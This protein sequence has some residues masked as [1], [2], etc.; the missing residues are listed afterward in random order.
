MHRQPDA[1]RQLQPCSQEGPPVETGPGTRERRGRNG[2]RRARHS[3]ARPILGRPLLLPR[4]G[5]GKIEAQTTNLHRFNAELYR[6]TD[7]TLYRQ[8]ALGY[9]GGADDNLPGDEY[10]GLSEHFGELM[11]RGAVVMPTRG[12]PNESVSA[13]LP[14]RDLLNRRREWIRQRSADN[15]RA[16]QEILASGARND[17][18][19]NETEPGLP[20]EFFADSSDFEAAA[21][22]LANPGV[23]ALVT[24]D[25]GSDCRDGKTVAEHKPC[26]QVVQWF[27]DT[28]IGLTFYEGSDKFDVVLRSLETGEALHGVV[29]LVTAGNRVLG[30]LATDANG[31]A[32]F[33]KSLTRGTQSNALAAIMAQ[34]DSDKGLGDFAFMTFNSERLDLSK[35]NVDG[36]TLPAG[37]DAFLT[38]DR[39]LYEPGQTIELVALL[40]D[41]KGE[42]IEAPPRA[43]VRLEARDRV[44][45]QAPIEPSEWKLGGARKSIVLPKEARS[46]PVRVVLSLGEGENAAV[47]ETLIHIGPIKPDQSTCSFPTPA[48]PGARAPITASSKSK[49]R[50]WRATCL[51]RKR[52]SSARRGICA[53]KPWRGFRPARPR[54]RPATGGSL[55]ANMTKAPSP[56]PR[57]HPC[58]SPTA[59]ATPRS[60]LP[61]S[62]FPSPRGPSPPRSR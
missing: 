1:G 27:I 47:G 54:R 59:T 39:G 5:A 52:T 44:L 58:S 49:G 37:V 15:K 34:V 50:S 20:G 57:F 3:R 62:T 38:T 41:A 25:P 11:W 35:L 43:M 23:Y 12:K 7:R 28:D 45:I 32:R 10:Q 21:G 55:S 60:T 8:I 9:V 13:L 26:D 16:S 2:S 29:Q 14:V 48:R 18:V 31:V 53:S 19:A 17:F 36:R 22:A 56:A 51:R 24:P 46:G 42:A 40:R 6:I 61:A 4:S 33:P 30:E